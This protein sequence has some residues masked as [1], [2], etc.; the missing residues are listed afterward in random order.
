[1]REHQIQDFM[2]NRFSNDDPHKDGD[3][4]IIKKKYEKRS[5]VHAA[6]KA[7]SNIEQAEDANL[8]SPREHLLQAF[9]SVE[10]LYRTSMAEEDPLT[11]ERIRHAVEITFNAL[12]QADADPESKGQ[13]KVELPDGR[14]QM[15]GVPVE[16]LISLLQE[17]ASHPNVPDDE[18]QQFI[19]QA[20]ILQN[21]SRAYFDIH[22]PKSDGGMHHPDHPDLEGRDEQQNPRTRLEAY[23]LS[24]PENR[25]YREVLAE[26]YPQFAEQT[27]HNDYQLAMEVMRTRRE[28]VPIAELPP[29]PT[30]ET[31]L[32]PIAAPEPKAKILNLGEQRKNRLGEL[33]QEIQDKFKVKAVDIV[34]KKKTDLEYIENAVKE[35]SDFTEYLGFT[36][37]D[38]QNA[39]ELVFLINNRRANS[40]DDSKRIYVSYDRIA[41]R[42]NWASVKEQIKN[43]WVNGPKILT[44]EE[45]KNSPL[46]QTLE[47]LRT[48]KHLDIDWAEGTQA[49]YFKRLKAVENIAQAVNGLDPMFSE[50]LTQ[51]K[52]VLY[53]NQKEP[54]SVE[55]KPGEIRWSIFFAG[56]DDAQDKIAEMLEGR[57]RSIK[58]RRIKEL[59]PNFKNQSFQG[60]EPRAVATVLQIM[61]QLESSNVPL[62]TFRTIVFTGGGRMN[63]FDLNKGILVLNR[64]V[65]S[66]QNVLQIAKIYEQ[67]K[68]TP[69]FD[70]DEEN[71]ESE[72]K[73]VVKKL[74]P[75]VPH[76]SQATESTPI[77]PTQNFVI[78]EKK[79]K[80]DTIKTPPDKISTTPKTP[81]TLKSSEVKGAKKEKKLSPE[82]RLTAY[83]NIAEQVH[84]NNPDKNQFLKKAEE[85]AEDWYEMDPENEFAFTEDQSLGQVKF[86]DK[87]MLYGIDEPTSDYYNAWKNQG[88]DHG[89]KDNVLDW[90]RYL[91]DPSTTVTSQ[92][93][94][95]Q[96]SILKH[97][98]EKYGT[99]EQKTRMA[100]IK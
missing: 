91:V 79:T 30:L 64:N 61:K 12:A 63:R 99:D 28:L 85:E 73:F 25:V 36:E 55:P 88:N 45:R 16:E 3:F 19:K 57:I 14:T 7:E 10:S 77:E 46:N 92:Q 42:N 32:E 96:E 66:A 69:K 97:L 95:N 8:D 53:G 59:N 52:I 20:E 41:D 9:R 22:Y 84:S 48:E 27:S 76:L 1:M 78:P 89:D 68:N 82:A 51:L 17:A 4:D 37:Q 23:F 98:I 94:Q 47:R 11:K 34:F 35:C 26:R 74:V 71:A 70:A 83:L 39:E 13:I 65:D 62:D 58:I 81:K 40:D 93:V 24:L 15:E 2:E 67:Y 49:D 86:D 54:D 21:E 44:D 50:E 33:N 5:P 87:T 6:S 80:K 43:F 72:R 31:T 75:R 56:E 38:W 100:E 29:E 60:L 90:A 18:K